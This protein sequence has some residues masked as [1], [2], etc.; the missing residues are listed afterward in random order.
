VRVRRADNEDRDEAGAQR[1]GLNAD[2]RSLL[3]GHEHNGKLPNLGAAQGACALLFQIF[4]SRNLREHRRL[5]CVDEA[6]RDQSM[7][8]KPSQKADEL[9]HRDQKCSRHADAQVRD[10]WNVSNNSM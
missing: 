2:M 10:R 3:Y 4:L 5:Q 1:F 9:D 8:D 6:L 7:G